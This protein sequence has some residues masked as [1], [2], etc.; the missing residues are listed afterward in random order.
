MEHDMTKDELDAIAKRESYC[1]PFETRVSLT[2]SERDQL[3]ALARHAIEQLPEVDFD[4]A[5]DWA[6]TY[7]AIAWHLIYRHGENWAHTGV[8]MERWA[9]AWVAAHPIAKE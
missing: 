6:K 3:V 9:R 1:A 7:P 5:Q 4:D 8:L 2:G